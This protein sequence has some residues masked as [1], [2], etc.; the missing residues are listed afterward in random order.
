MINICDIYMAIFN[1]TMKQ[2]KMVVGKGVTYANSKFS[3][4]NLN[5]Q[6]QIEW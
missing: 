2:G 5:R 4:D 6:I 3:L 1:A